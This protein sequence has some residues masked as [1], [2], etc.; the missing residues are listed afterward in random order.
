MVQLVCDSCAKVKGVANDW[1]LGTLS[2]TGE[3]SILSGW[4][5]EQAFNPQ[6]VHFCSELC[7]NR[8]MATAF[9]RSVVERN[10]AYRDIRVA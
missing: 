10:L 7:E 4:P 9:V 6:A 5:E 1:I 2:A 8:Y 3:L